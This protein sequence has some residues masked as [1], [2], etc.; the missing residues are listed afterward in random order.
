MPPAF[1]EVAAY[2]AEITGVP[3]FAVEVPMQWGYWSDN[4]KARTLI[5]YEPQC[6]LENIFDTALADQVGEP[7]DV[8]SA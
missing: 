2:L 3:L 5:G 7:T 4:S 1:P 8:I 6:T